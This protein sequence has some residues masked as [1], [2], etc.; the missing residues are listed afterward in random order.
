[1]K[2]VILATVFLLAGFILGAFL[3]PTT[4]RATGLSLG[5]VQK[6][7]VSGGGSSVYGTLGDTTVIGISCVPDEGA[8]ACYVLTK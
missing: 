3:H 6:V 2:S 4:A 8:A 7:H 1:M 5:N